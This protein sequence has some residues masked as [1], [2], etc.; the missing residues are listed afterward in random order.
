MLDV[1]C[2]QRGVEFLDTSQPGLELEGHIPSL[3]PS[4]L[5]GMMT[6]GDN[7]DR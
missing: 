1:G 3:Y 5:G 4:C 6:E 7:Y 2:G